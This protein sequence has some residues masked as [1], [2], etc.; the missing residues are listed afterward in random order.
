[1]TKAFIDNKVTIMSGAG[2][3]VSTMVA[4]FSLHNA[5][6]SLSKSALTNSQ[7][8]DSAIFEPSI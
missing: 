2:A 3:N 8:L 5:L 1:M 4:G 7:A 6:Q